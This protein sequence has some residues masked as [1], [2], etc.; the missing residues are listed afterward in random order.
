MLADFKSIRRFVPTEFL[1][2]RRK[3]KNAAPQRKRV[4]ESQ[5]IGKIV[6]EEIKD[7]PKKAKTENE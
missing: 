7:E 4:L 6:H 1:P 5:E 2:P 3:E